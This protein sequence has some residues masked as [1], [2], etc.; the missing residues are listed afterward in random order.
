MDIKSE[1]KPAGILFFHEIFRENA[2]CMSHRTGIPILRNVDIVQG[3]RIKL[4]IFG[5]HIKVEEL[6]TL[7]E[8]HFP[9]VE[10]VILQT[11]QLESRFFNG[12]R[13]VHLLSLDSNKIYDWSCRNMAYLHVSYGIDFEGIFDYEFP[14]ISENNM[15]P[16]HEREID[17]F[18]LGSLNN[19]RINILNKIKETFSYLNIEI[20]SFSKENEQYQN[21]KVLTEKLLNVKY[22]LN[23]PFYPNSALETHRINKALSCGC[24]VISQLSA[25]TKLNN[26]YKIF[27]YLRKDIIKGI[28]NAMQMEAPPKKKYVQSHNIILS[29]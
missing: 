28:Y 3:Q 17:L 26:E 13:Y 27:I 6:I 12:G 22:V 19:Y 9:N 15:K 8:K 18:F 4:I 16:F 21:A 25:D 24:Q 7:Y 29:F 2:V 11:E 1:L 23:I 14:Q 10:Y 5:A 20:I